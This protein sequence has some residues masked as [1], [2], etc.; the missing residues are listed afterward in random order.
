MLEPADGAS[1]AACDAGAAV[2]DVEGV[3]EVAEGVAVAV[4]QQPVVAEVAEE[5]V[6]GQ[7]QPA[8]AESCEQSE[9]DPVWAEESQSEPAWA[10]F[11]DFATVPSTGD[12][13]PASTG[14]GQGTTAWEAPEDASAAASDPNEPARAVFATTAA[15]H[16]GG[17]FATTAPTA[18]GDAATPHSD[19]AGTAANILEVVG[20]DFTEP[21]NVLAT[22][23][24]THL[25]QPG[26]GTRSSGD[27][28]ATLDTG[29]PATLDAAP[30]RDGTWPPCY[31]ALAD[32]GRGV[33]A[34]VTPWP[35]LQRLPRHFGNAVGLQ[36][37]DLDPQVNGAGGDGGGVGGVDAATAATASAERVRLLFKPR[38]LSTSKGQDEIL[39]RD[40]RASLAPLALRSR[41]RSSGDDIHEVR[42]CVTAALRWLACVI[43][44]HNCCVA[45]LHWP[46]LPCLWLKTSWPSSTLV[47]TLPQ[48]CTG[49]CGPML[50]H[51]VTREAPC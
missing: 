32:A 28:P 31:A 41:S 48:T 12:A 40:R 8:A 11:N 47:T 35:V 7:Q 2:E 33:A 10:D 49:A 6:E 18:P 13:F 21:G 4:Q 22:L 43:P 19:S 9:P 34:Q 5:A 3:A 38:R 51:M 1:I 23:V 27:G 17:G 16:A 39:S 36:D 45:C 30:A 37:L 15:P 29:G 46:S 25:C 14:D 24:A 20:R 50:A 42:P 26:A 44:V